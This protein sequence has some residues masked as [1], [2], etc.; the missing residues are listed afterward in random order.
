[1]SNLDEHASARRISATRLQER[2][3]SLPRPDT[4]SV[5]EWSNVLRQRRETEVSLAEDLTGW[6]GCRLVRSPSGT[7]VC[8]LL[9]GLSVFSR[10]GVVG[11]CRAW[12]AAVDELGAQTQ[13]FPQVRRQRRS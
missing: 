13:G 2:L 9:D 3:A 7:Y 11:A 10:A 5:T 8:L 6:P 1:M 12:L 4:H